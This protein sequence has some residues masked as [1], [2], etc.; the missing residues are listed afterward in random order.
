MS[1]CT[2]YFPC[3]HVEREKNSNQIK[4]LA[5]RMPNIYTSGTRNLQYYIIETRDYKICMYCIYDMYKTNF[6]ICNAIYVQYT[7][8]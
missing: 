6:S 5:Q 2:D 1:K 3:N 4:Q 8:A 7:N